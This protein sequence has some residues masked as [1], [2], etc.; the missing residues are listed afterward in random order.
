[1]IKPQE[2]KITALPGG[3]EALVDKSGNEV[4]RKTYSIKEFCL[5]YRMGRSSCFQ[6]IKSGRLKSY[7]RG[8]SRRI[9][10]EAAEAW[11]TLLEG[12]GKK[13]GKA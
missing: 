6:E 2:Y 1:M 7:K 8:R 13:R 11:Q 9:S 10:K 12:Q 4:E 5:A 3:R